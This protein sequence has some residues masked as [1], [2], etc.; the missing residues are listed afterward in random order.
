MRATIKMLLVAALLLLGVR[1]AV[2]SVR[3]GSFDGS[4]INYSG[5]PLSGSAHST[6]RGIIQA[7]D[8]IIAPATSSLTP[9]Y[10]DDV[11]V[12]YT[13]LLD[14]STG[15]LS[16]AEQAALQGWIASGGTLI[17]SADYLSLAAYESFTSPYGVTGYQALTN[18]GTGWPV[19][20]HMITQGIGG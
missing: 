18:W 19:A 12:F 13:S 11:D 7:N 6:L 5:G 8:G 4:R 16:S 9:G 2:A 10:L 3:W 17:V 15:H 1:E 14:R 20:T